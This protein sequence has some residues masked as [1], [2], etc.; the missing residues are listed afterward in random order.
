MTINTH[1]GLC[2]AE[3]ATFFAN[4]TKVQW[5]K[6]ETFSFEDSFEHWGNHASEAPLA[7]AIFMIWQMHP[8]V[9][10][11]HCNGHNRTQA[12]Q[13]GTKHMDQQHMSMGDMRHDCDNSMPRMD[14][15]LS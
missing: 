15:K 3:G 9:T 10:H 14:A 13:L 4:G 5:G 6:G 7:E 11:K 12:E 2:G 8:H 1:T